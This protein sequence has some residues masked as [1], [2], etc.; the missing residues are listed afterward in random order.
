MPAAV[1][2]RRTLRLVSLAIQPSDC[3]PVIKSGLPDFRDNDDAIGGTPFLMVI[4]K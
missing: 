3:G 2:H 4:T 1:P